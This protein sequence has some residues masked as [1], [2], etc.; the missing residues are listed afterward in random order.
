MPLLCLGCGALL[1]GPVGASVNRAIKTPSR[2]QSMTAAE[3]FGRSD[4]G[5]DKALKLRLATLIPAPLTAKSQSRYLLSGKGQKETNFVCKLSK[6][7]RKSNYLLL[8][9]CVSSRK[10]TKLIR[11]CFEGISTFWSLDHRRSTDSPNRVFCKELCA[12]WII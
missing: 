4:P 8:T 5:E 12:G 1:A 6:Q 2:S 10:K 7:T 9:P 3:S 11:P